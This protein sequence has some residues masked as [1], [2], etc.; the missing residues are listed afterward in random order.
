MPLAQLTAPYDVNFVLALCKKSPN[1]KLGDRSFRQ[2]D[3]KVVK[4]LSVS[5]NQKKKLLQNTWK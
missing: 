3:N 2:D 4:W 5:M 1:V